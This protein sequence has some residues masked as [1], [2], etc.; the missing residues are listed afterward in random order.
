M[1]SGIT[2]DTSPM[3]SQAI[4]LINIFM[5]FIYI[6]GGIAIFGL[7]MIIVVAIARRSAG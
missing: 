1:W 4:E 3:V 7:V 6:I 2:F 5:P